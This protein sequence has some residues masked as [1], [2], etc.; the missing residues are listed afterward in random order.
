MIALILTLFFASPDSVW[1][2]ADTTSTIL[3]QFNEPMDSLSLINI[4]NY[5]VI[6]SATSQNYRIYR[7]GLP[8]GQNNAVVLI[9]ERLRYKRTAIIIANGVKDKAGNLI[10]PQKNKFYF[11]HKGL[12]ESIPK[13]IVR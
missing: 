7:V 5:S 13:P 12:K 4:S 3:L 6:D 11:Y 1:I 8:S 9:C 2:N 10:N